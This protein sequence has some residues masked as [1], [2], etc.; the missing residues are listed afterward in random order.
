MRVK[1]HEHNIQRK[2]FSMKKPERGNALRRVSV[3]GILV[4]A[5]ALG[6]CAAGTILKAN[7]V[8]TAAVMKIDAGQQK[9]NVIRFQTYGPEAEQIFGYFLY[10]DGI[11]VVT[12]GGTQVV[13]MG[14]LTLAD[15]MADY[16]HIRKSMMYSSGSGL[17]V[18][19]IIRGS[20]IAG[21]T[22]ADSNIDVGIWDVTI[23]GKESG[24]ILQLIYNDA[25]GQH[26]GGT[27]RG[28]PLS[29]D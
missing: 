3:V 25:R 24:A 15:V 4:A 12:G 1:R 2:E 22:A 23:G 7:E 6:A 9:L 14:K 11:E 17:V 26:D 29:G 20:S 28:R 18:K 16:N 19:E 10:R 5:L 8:D 27:Y 21:Y 13:N